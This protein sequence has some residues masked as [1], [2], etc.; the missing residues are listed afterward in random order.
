MT[1]NGCGRVHGSH[2]RDA[3]H[4]DEVKVSV[5]EAL[6]AD[7]LL[8]E[9]DKL[10]GVVLVGAG[11]IDILKVDDQSLALFGPVDSTL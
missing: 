4:R 7:D 10:N 2:N 3:L 1:A 9:R 8:E 11:Q 6:V 5:V